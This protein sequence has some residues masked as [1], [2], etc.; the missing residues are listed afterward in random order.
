[1]IWKKLDLLVA[2]A[3]VNHHG[4]VVAE[5][6]KGVS[7]QDVV[8]V[9]C[10]R[11]LDLR[12]DQR[13]SKLSTSDASLESV[14]DH[15]EDVLRAT[16][17]SQ[18]TVYSMSGCMPKAKVKAQEHLWNVFWFRLAKKFHEVLDSKARSRL[19]SDAKV[20]LDV[21]C[22]LRS[23]Q[24]F[25]IGFSNWRIDVNGLLCSKSSESRFDI[26]IVNFYHFCFWWFS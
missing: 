25:R 16:C 22:L 23:L 18:K 21:I 11:C 4:P 5:E 3:L 9:C 6:D 17:R 8:E 24:H 10:H 15:V 1:M 20:H 7:L 26:L 14:G 2:K 19:A 12:P 13:R